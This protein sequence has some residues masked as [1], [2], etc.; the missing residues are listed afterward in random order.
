MEKQP[1]LSTTDIQRYVQDVASRLQSTSGSHNR[2][3]VIQTLLTK[4]QMLPDDEFEVAR[5]TVETLLARTAEKSTA[6]PTRQLD[7]LQSVDRALNP[8]RQNQG[9]QK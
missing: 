9:N 8:D 7:P 1:T 2:L 6:I 5:L 4:L 3:N